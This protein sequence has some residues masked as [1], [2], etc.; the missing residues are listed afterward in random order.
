MLL[1]YILQTL[2]PTVVLP[3]PYYELKMKYKAFMYHRMCVFEIITVNWNFLLP[4][5]LEK[6]SRQQNFLSKL[7]SHKF[8]VNKKSY[9]WPIC[10]TI[11]PTNFLFHIAVPPRV[12]LSLGRL[13]NPDD[14]EEGDDLYFS[15]SIVSNPPHYKLTWWHNVSC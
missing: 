1:G 15:C 10:N 13:V 8:K 6:E 7:Q 12:E 3:S 5:F 9:S 2:L 4:I 14:L 11:K